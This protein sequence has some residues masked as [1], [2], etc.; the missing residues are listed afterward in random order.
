MAVTGNLNQIARRYRPIRLKLAY[1]SSVV[2]D[3]LHRS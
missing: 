3:L 2:D 1:L